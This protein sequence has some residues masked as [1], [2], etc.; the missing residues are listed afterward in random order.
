MGFKI[1]RLIFRGNVDCFAACLNRRNAL[2]HFVYMTGRPNTLILKFPSTAKKNHQDYRFAGLRA[3]A[4]QLISSILRDF[5]PDCRLMQRLRRNRHSQK[6]FS[7]IKLKLKE[8]LSLFHTKKKS[9]VREFS[10]CLKSR[11]NNISCRQVPTQCMKS[12]EVV[13]RVPESRKIRNPGLQCN[14]AQRYP[15]SS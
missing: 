3:V 9:G 10:T 11:F 15:K 1:I 13:I 8:I 5:E 12:P 6:Q 4:W 7:I 14:S 2:K